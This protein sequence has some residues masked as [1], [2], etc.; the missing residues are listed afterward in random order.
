MQPR[1]FGALILC[2]GS[3]IELDSILITC[4]VFG[5]QHKYVF[6]G[7]KL[8]S[9]TLP[10]FKIVFHNYALF[11]A[12]LGV[13]THFFPL[14]YNE[15][16]NYDHRGE[17]PADNFFYSFCDT[18]E[19]KKAKAIFLQEQRTGKEEWIFTDRLIEY[20]SHRARILLKAVTKFTRTSFRFQKGLIKSN[21]CVRQPDLSK[22]MPYLFPLQFCSL[23]AYAFAVGKAFCVE[24]SHLYSVM[25][26]HLQLGLVNRVSKV[27]H[28]ALCFEEY[29]RDIEIETAYSSAVG[30]RTLFFGDE[31]MVCDGYVLEDSG[32]ELVFQ[33]LGCFWHQHDKNICHF[34]DKWKLTGLGGK[35]FTQTWTE[36]NRKNGLLTEDRQGK[37]EIEVITIWECEHNLKKENVTS[38]LHVFLRD[39]Y[40]SRPLRRLVSRSVNR[41]ALVEAYHLKSKAVPELVVVEN[42]DAVSLYPHIAR[43]NLP[44]GPYIILAGKAVD[45][46]YYNLVAESY[47]REGSK[48]IGLCFVS[49]L[50]PRTLNI[51]FM[52]Y[53]TPEE[54]NILGL[55]KT[56]M[57]KESYEECLH[58]DQERTFEG[59][60]TCEEVSYATLLDYKVTFYEVLSFAAESPIL[61]PFMLYLFNQKLRCSGFPHNIITEEQ[62]EKH[63]KD[64][65][66]LHNFHES[67]ALSPKLIQRNEGKRTTM[68]SILNNYLGKFN[69]NP[70]R[71]DTILCYTQKDYEKVRHSRDHKITSDRSVGNCLRQ[72]TVINKNL[73]RVPNRKGN[74]VLHNHIMSGAR[75][76][77]HKAAMECEVA[78]CKV[79][80]IQTDALVLEH[81]PKDKVPLT[82]CPGLGGFQPVYPIEDILCFLTLGTSSCSFLLEN[83]ENKNTRCQLKIQGFKFESAVS[84]NQMSF[85]LFEDLFQKRLDDI[86]KTVSVTQSRTV[87]LQLKQFKAVLRE[88]N[89]GNIL[90]R[91]RITIVNGGTF[92]TYPFGT[93]NITF[94]NVLPPPPSPSI[95]DI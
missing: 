84:A 5:V 20:T 56:C 47:Y 13:E 6:K 22:H 91:R 67:I 43:G 76:F 21:A 77:I 12:N 81:A 19:E 75:I 66:E 9:V 59:C 3:G 92:Q 73:S 8:I 39:R 79:L 64:M 83:R 38:E 28:E 54:K 88:H 48:L 27:E 74:S 85:E 50:P 86:S 65:N 4:T 78:N 11:Y 7:P 15:P 53:K 58:T 36:I 70:E 49:L 16:K 94:C 45:A 46:I 44:I 26:E 1:Y 30:Q 32:K 18:V 71:S 62:K 25:S 37:N 14:Q 61:K 34:P 31:R 95:C 52:F 80:M 17:W 90:S 35:D 29:K 69:E 89:L 68:K 23:S 51:P 57:D 10:E 60:Y 55:C 42:F 82:I 40:K 63:C 93:K 72:L 24:P 87:K 2:H 33:I 41:P